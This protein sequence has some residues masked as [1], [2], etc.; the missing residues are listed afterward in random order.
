MLGA[1][2]IHLHSLPLVYLG[3]GCMAGTGLG[4]SI[5][6]R[7]ALLMGGDLTVVSAPGEGSTFE[8]TIPLEPAA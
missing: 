5:S 3:Y 4:L 7:L 1:A 2:G 6:R 8:L